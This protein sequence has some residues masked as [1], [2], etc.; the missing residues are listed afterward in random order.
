MDILTLKLKLRMIWVHPCYLEGPDSHHFDAGIHY[1]WKLVKMSKTPPMDICMLKLKLIT[2]WVHPTYLEG[3]NSHHFDAG[4]HFLWKLANKCKKNQNGY[5][6]AQI[7]A[8]NE[9]S[10]FMLSMRSYF[11]SFWCKCPVEEK[12]DKQM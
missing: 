7:E 12:I 10:T 1:L 4:I 3:S 9:M 11:A 6:Y 5:S 2:T 8:E